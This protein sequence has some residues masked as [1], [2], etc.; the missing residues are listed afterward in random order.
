MSITN[1]KNDTYPSGLNEAQIEQLY[2]KVDILYLLIDPKGCIA[3][4]NTTFLEA[5]DTE[6]EFILGKNFL[7]FVRSDLRET[8]YSEIA[9][10]LQRGYIRSVQTV[11]CPDSRKPIHVLLNGLTLEEADGLLPSV[12]VYI[13]DITALV[14]NGQR[15][16]LL[17]R[18]VQ[19]ALQRVPNERL[20]REILSDI[21]KT[22]ECDGIGL[23]LNKSTGEK[24]C[25]GNW[26]AFEDGGADTDFR[27]WT[28]DKWKTLADRL[29]VGVPSDTVREKRILLS[30]TGETG[31]LTSNSETVQLLAAFGNYRS[32][33]AVPIPH[34]SFSGY[35]IF[36]DRRASQF[37]SDDL[38]FFVELAS[39]LP[40]FLLMQTI[41]S[42]SPA[43]PEKPEVGLPS[44][45][46]AG[47]LVTR[48][49]LI[50]RS[51]PWVQR[52]LAADEELLRGKLLVEFVD[53]DFQHVLLDMQGP[54]NAEPIKLKVWTL[55]G[56]ARFVLC[57]AEKVAV[58]ADEDQVWY[59]LD[60]PEMIDPK[61][62]ILQ[63][64]KME[65]L[66]MLAGSIVLDFNNQLACILGY[67]SLLSEEISPGSPHYQ[68]LQQ[69]ITTTEKA[70][71]LTSRLL[72]CAQGSPYVVEGLDVNPMINE[73]A[74]I[75]SKT[76]SKDLLIRAELDPFLHRI[77]GDASRI[78]QSILEIAL[79][80]KQAM[81]NGGKIVFQTRN[82]VLGEKDLRS[83]QGLK[84]GDYIQITISDSGYGMTAELKKQLFDSASDLTG[85]GGVGLSLV[86]QTVEDQSG[87]ISVFSEK[88]QGT[89][90]KIT[91]PAQ[92]KHAHRSVE[93]KKGELSGGRETILLVD[94]ETALR[95]TGQK[96]LKRYGYQVIPA[97]NGN[98]ALELY[99]KHGSK[100]DLI[101]L[102]MM[103]P[104]VEINKILEWFY[105]FNPKTKILAAV[106][107]GERDSVE[108]SLRF[109][110]T[111]FVQKPFHIRP[112]IHSIRAILNA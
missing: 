110:V 101:L 55:E 52:F 86:R 81:P 112:L 65:T 109:D 92:D 24:Q 44:I 28:P 71:E 8:L 16:D 4:C 29:E 15:K 11:L 63:M 90:F 111:G 43:V 19:T 45:P 30:D 41:P 7:D 104:G 38:A 37:D 40:G 33:A 94:D 74:G 85:D 17:A 62:Q 69:I 1:Y 78:Q 25:L 22:Q 6:K 9:K 84:P 32:L 75:M 54:E 18:L 47:I 83:R 50:Q 12:R 46:F 51:N 39:L 61:Q 87:F 21:Q 23:S 97:E 82:T 2:S 79:N 77:H 13:Q 100:I 96:M 70:V 31:A 58:S 34:E 20:L 66:G 35:V 60:I 14:R 56:K 108:K 76:F 98:Q 59:W 53:P 36:S 72:A 89:V 5:F 91:L 80:A 68:D 106:G 73:I 67:S 95:D 48:N 99:K 103:L 105:K 42:E 57:A 64:K 26:K 49:G 3:S 93:T 88:G 10:C 107:A 27:R 102:D